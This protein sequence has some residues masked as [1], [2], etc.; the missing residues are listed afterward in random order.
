M[1]QD[2]RAIIRAASM[3]QAASDWMFEKAGEGPVHNIQPLA[4]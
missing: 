3:A 4:A 1:Q 2:S